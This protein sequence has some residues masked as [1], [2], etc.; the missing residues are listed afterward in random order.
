MIQHFTGVIEQEDDPRDY[1]VRLV[2]ATQYP[3][4]AIKECSV[5]NSDQ[6]VGKCVMCSLEAAFTEF[7]GDAVGGNWGYGYFRT[8]KLSGMYPREAPRLVFNYEAVL[9]PQPSETE[10]MAAALAL[11]GV[12]PEEGA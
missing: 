5:P 6:K 9:E 12:E 2:G 10:D 7:Y 11:L 1:S 8:H 4:E 3:D